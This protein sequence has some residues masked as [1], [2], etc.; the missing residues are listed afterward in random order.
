MTAAGATMGSGPELRLRAR[1]VDG[2]LEATLTSGRLGAARTLGAGTLAWRPELAVEVTTQMAAILS[3][4]T[5]FGD[6]DRGSFEALR[7][8]GELLYGELLPASIVAALRASPDGILS[9]ELDAALAAL[10]WEL[11][12]DG[13][14]FLALRHAVGRISPSATPLAAGPRAA[15]PRLR[16]LVVCDPLGD[17][18]GAYYEGLLLRD[19]LGAGTRDVQMDLL[20]T[21]VRLTDL[22]RLWRDYDVI[23]YAGHGKRLAG[24]PETGAWLLEDGALTRSDLLRL[25]DGARWPRLVFSNACR[26]AAPSDDSPPSGPDAESSFAAT[27]LACGA[28]HFVGPRWDVPDEP[29]CHLALAFHRAAFAGAPVGVA[30]RAARRALL[31]RYGPGSVFWASYVL[32]G[33]PAEGVRPATP[34]D[35]TGLGAPQTRARPLPRAPVSTPEPPR[36]ALLRLRKH[37]A[38]TRSGVTQMPRRPSLASRASFAVALVVLAATAAFV[39]HRWWPP[40]ATPTLIQ[41]TRGPDLDVVAL[42]GTPEARPVASGAALAP[43]AR[44][45]VTLDVAGEPSVALWRLESSGTVARLY[46]AP[47]GTLLRPPTDPQHWPSGRGSWAPAARPDRVAFVLTTGDVEGMAQPIA[48]ERELAALLTETGSG[49][50]LDAAVGRLASQSERVRV[51]VVSW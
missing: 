43:D 42:D 35:A 36:P 10:P 14:S 3:G 33:D 22:K 41:P 32:Y 15:P 20:G 30:L 4:A 31:E 26:S 1:V 49:A 19:E 48:R 24:S 45:R 7:P 5:R 51:V 2:L 46:P 12:H 18:M 34:S 13:R 38:E 8:F 28:R 11:L 29:A 17:L 47:H 39:T 44:I 9:L 25:S 23:H 16:M 50:S 27:F 40:G 6:D 37:S 21:E